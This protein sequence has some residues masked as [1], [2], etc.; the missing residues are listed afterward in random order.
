MSTNETDGT[1]RS[2][3]NNEGSKSGNDAG[4]GKSEGE[5][6]GYDPSENPKIYP[7]SINTLKQAKAAQKRMQ[8]RL[9]WIKS[10]LP[11][12]VQLTE[13]ADDTLLQQSLISEYD[14]LAAE[15]NSLIVKRPLLNVR[16]TGLEEEAA[17]AVK[18]HTFQNVDWD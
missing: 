3:D 14:R 16:L 5:K 9:D 8:Q 12:I 11:E 2:T 18:N 10:R 1:D 15:V 6:K 7:Q 4:K 17:L 13:E